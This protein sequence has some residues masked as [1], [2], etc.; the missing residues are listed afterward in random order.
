MILGKP[1]LEREVHF[2][3]YFGNRNLITVR[4][5]ALR[6]TFLTPKGGKMNSLPLP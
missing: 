2:Y 4:E 3:S 5:M 1:S 6:N